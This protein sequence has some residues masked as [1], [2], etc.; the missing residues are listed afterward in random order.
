MRKEQSRTVPASNFMGTLASNVGNL[1]LTDAQFRVLFRNTQPI[2]A[3]ADCERIEK[4]LREKLSL[5]NL[6]RIFAGKEVML[7]AVFAGGTTMGL[8]RG[9]C[10]GFKNCA[11]GGVILVITEE[12]RQYP[13]TP[14][15]ISRSGDKVEGFI[16]RDALD[17]YRIELV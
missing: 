15:S 2:V 8:I 13:F 17:R 7:K 5:E 1:D 16:S 11:D 9:A 14:D 10:K 4:E 3:Y 6:N 12:D